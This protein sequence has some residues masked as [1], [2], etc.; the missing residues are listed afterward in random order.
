MSAELQADVGADRAWSPL[1]TVLGT[2][3][4][5]RGRPNVSGDLPT[6][7]RA[8]PMFRRAV[9]GYDR[10][11]VDTYVQWAEDEIATADREREHLVERH[12][13]TQ[14]A[15]AEARQ[16]LGHSS[17][18]GEFLGLS[19]RIGT[20]LAAA[21][22]E[23]ESM[24]AEAEAHRSTASAQAEAMVARAERVLADAEAEAGR[25][26][27]EAATQ[28]QQTTAEAG[29]ILAEAEQTGEDARAEAAARLEEVRGIEQRAA[30]RARRI[31]RRA[32]EDAVAARLQ[33]RD[34]VVRMLSTGREERRRADAEAAATRER[35]DRDAAARSAILLAELET[36]ERRRS[37]LRAEVELL[38]APVAGK[39][40][41]HLRRQLLDRLRWWS[42]SLR[43]H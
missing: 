18:G 15:L 25:M 28:A 41:G 4:R 1:E 40:G 36:L 3:P 16:L 10:F 29:R 11:Q 5:D 26:V 13:R 9:A 20:L 31:E 32:A 30:E 14:A 6:V 39:T 12:L 8:G 22:D 24:R 2:E 43:T 27:A 23:A 33:A 17:G 34:E 7:L 42:R 19:R 38:P 21:A 35:L 37:A